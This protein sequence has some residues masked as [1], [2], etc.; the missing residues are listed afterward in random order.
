MRMME[1]GRGVR[2]ARMTY[3]MTSII[4]WQ[5]TMRREAESMSREIEMLNRQVNSMRRRL[6][7]MR[8]ISGVESSSGGGEMDQ[9]TL[10]ID[11]INEQVNSFPHEADGKVV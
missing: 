11:E 4:W 1:V 5:L 8:D 10:K 3:G 9:L 6:K 2:E 7:S